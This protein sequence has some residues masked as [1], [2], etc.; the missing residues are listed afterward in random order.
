MPLSGIYSFHQP[1]IEEKSG[2]EGIEKTSE[3]TVATAI[4]RIRQK[5]FFFTKT[6][7][8]IKN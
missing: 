6:P 7:K 2:V 3:N 5:N 4:R 1:G 8:K